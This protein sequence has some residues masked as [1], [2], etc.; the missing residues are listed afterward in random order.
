MKAKDKAEK[1]LSRKAYVVK[2][3]K[4]IQ[5]K[6]DKF[7]GRIFTEEL[8]KEIKIAIESSQMDAEVCNLKKQ[9]R[10]KVTLKFDADVDKQTKILKSILVTDTAEKTNTVH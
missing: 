10:H 9:C 8:K 5:P 3:L 2:L 7:N 1:S 4:L 6:F